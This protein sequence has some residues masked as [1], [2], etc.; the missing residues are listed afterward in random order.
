MRHGGR[1]M[2]Y[3]PNPGQFTACCGANVH[4]IFPNY[5]IRMWMKTNDGGLAAV[6]YGPSTVNAAVGADNEPVEIVQTTTYP[7]DEQ[8]Q[9]K[10]RC[11]R[12]VSF[13]LAFRIPAWCDDP[14]LSVNG[15]SAAASRTHNG[16][17]VL[18]HSFNPGDVVSLTLPMKLAATFWPQNGIAIERGPLVY[19]LPIPEEWTAIVEPGYST[20]EFPS[21]EARPAG[22]WNYAIALDPAKLA[23]E[24]EI[25][26]KPLTQIEAVD[27]WGNPATTLTVPARKIAGWELQS[28][29]ANGGQ[30]FTPP[31]P[32]LSV[33]KISETTERVTLVPFGSTQ[34]RVTVF[35]LLRS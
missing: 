34:L 2:A 21:L 27:P 24:V 22:A 7:F 17:L 23:T 6:L 29:A 28:A 32:D 14:R 26:T 33:C 30:T 13:P 8:I 25:K 12:A 5:V 20:A 19:S 11:S 10:I 15:A 35:P 3:Q 1:L 31:L 16:F 4:R 18:R 9:F